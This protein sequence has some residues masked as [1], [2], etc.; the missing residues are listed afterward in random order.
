MPL[1]VGSNFR[2][3]QR[4]LRR[5][6]FP[7]HAGHPAPPSHRRGCLFLGLVTLRISEA[8]LAST[9]QIRC[10]CGARQI[11]GNILVQSRDAPIRPD[12]SCVRCFTPVT[13]APF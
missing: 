6:I 4:C 13:G 5:L 8:R 12:A 11:S 3:D 1:D 10:D 9:A 2:E 7:A